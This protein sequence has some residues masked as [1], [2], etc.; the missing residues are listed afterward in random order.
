MYEYKGVK[1]IQ[2]SNIHVKLSIDEIVIANVFFKRKF[3][4]NEIVIAN[5]FFKRKFPR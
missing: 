4:M 5:E 3:Q 2:R 1:N